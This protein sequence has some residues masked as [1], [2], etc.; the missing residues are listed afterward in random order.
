MYAATITRHVKVISEVPYTHALAEVLESRRILWRR[1][2]HAADCMFLDRLQADEIDPIG[3]FNVW[4]WR[5]T[6]LTL[7]KSLIIA[8]S[9]LCFSSKILREPRRADQPI[10]NFLIGTQE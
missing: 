9:T 8:M 3:N 5:G 1:V 4:I 10:V 2:D 7:P 6:Y